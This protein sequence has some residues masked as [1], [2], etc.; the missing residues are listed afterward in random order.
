MKVFAVLMASVVF[1]IPILALISLAPEWGD[2][3]ESPALPQY[4]FYMFLCLIHMIYLGV[5]FVLTQKKE[6]KE[7]EEETTENKK[8]SVPKGF[9]S[10]I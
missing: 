4:E 6:A 1:L 2:L 3:N 10:R 5:I 9:Q 7:K 8:W